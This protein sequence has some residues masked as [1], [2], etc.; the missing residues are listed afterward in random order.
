ML[1]IN[2]VTRISKI[3]SN[4]ILELNNMISSEREIEF[5]ESIINHE[6]NITL[7]FLLMY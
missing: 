3:D 5:I 4:T 6:N 1:Y 2:D 7:N